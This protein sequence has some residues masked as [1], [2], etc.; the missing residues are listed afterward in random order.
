MSPTQISRRQLIKSGL[1]AAASSRLLMAGEHQA[2]AEDQ[3]AFELS[4]ICSSAMY[5]TMKLSE[6]LPEVRKT[7]ATTLDLWPK[8]H[9]SQHEE[10]VAMGPGKF[11]QMLVDHEVGLGG[12]AC[13]RYGAFKLQ[14]QMELATALGGKDVVLVCTGVGPRETK[15][16]ELRK[17]VAKF[18]EQLKPH[19]EKA[20]KH[21]CIIAIE[22]HSNN[23]ISSPDSMKWFGEMASEMPALG[24]AYAPHHLPQDADMQAKLIVSLGSAIQFFYAQQHGKGA[25]KKMPKEDELLQ[26][27]GRGSLDFRPLLGALRAIKFTGPTEIFM[28]PFPRGLPIL[29]SANAITA[30][31]N[32]SREY[33]EACLSKDA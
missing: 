15:G 10:A 27:P 22:N 33:L 17:A 5:G 3:E 13:Y 19:H 2:I 25:K 8:P 7:G 28:H 31:I 24:I 30:E 11:A 21:D 26:M 1:A 20:L 32:R 16:E 29:D 18:V 14:P 9:G 23:L 6:V 12:I 4:Y